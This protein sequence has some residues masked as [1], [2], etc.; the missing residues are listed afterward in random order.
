MN[1][2]DFTDI[3]IKKIRF[4]CPDIKEDPGRHYLRY[5]KDILEFGTPVGT[6]LGTGIGLLHHKL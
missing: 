2:Y 3:N 5:N 4:K 6:I 1:T